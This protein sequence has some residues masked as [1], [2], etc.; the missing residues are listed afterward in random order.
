MRKV[1]VPEGRETM[2]VGPEVDVAA[3]ATS[4][5]QRIRAYADFILGSPGW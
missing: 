2:D 1:T 3:A 4:S 5:A